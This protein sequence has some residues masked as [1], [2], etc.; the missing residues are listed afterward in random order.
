MATQNDGALLL[1]LLTWGSTSGVDD[2][3]RSVFQSDF[4]IAPTTPEECGDPD[5]GK[6][7][8]FGET[9]ATLVK[10]GV[11][12]AALVRDLIW[13]EGIWA[14]VSEYALA[15]RKGENEPRLYENM[16]AFALGR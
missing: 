9:T 16:E 7:L 11:L 1:Q 5:V 15:I 13:V 6:V 3:M 10:H 4:N 14:R 12:D 2:A 8:S